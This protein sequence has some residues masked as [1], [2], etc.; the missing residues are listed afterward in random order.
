[1][2]ALP[3]LPYA[4]T[5]LEPVIDERT[6]RIHHEKHH[7]GYVEKLNAAIST[8]DQYSGVSIEAILRD[9]DAVPENIRTAVRNNGGGHANHSLYWTVMG[10]GGG[11]RPSGNVEKA[12]E[13]TFG[14]FETFQDSFNATALGIFGSGWVFLVVA[15]G[16]LAIMDTPNQDSPL[17]KGMTPILGL[18]VWEH[19]YYLTYQ[20]RRFEYIERW[21][22]VVNWQEV[23]RRFA[24]SV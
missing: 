17:S 9:I 12:I 16:K 7:G 18:D 10:P 8:L 22:N 11:G 4:Y 15:E 1:M 6:M 3:K 23:E 13:Q 19:A 14:S 2:F 24:Q 20:N 5:A 21:W